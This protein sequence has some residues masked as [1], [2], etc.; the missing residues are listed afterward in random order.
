MYLPPGRRAA[1]LL[2]RRMRLVHDDRL[3]NDP[4]LPAL[5]RQTS[6]ELHVVEEDRVALVE[7]VVVRQERRVEAAGSSPT[8]AGRP[9]A[10]RN[11]RRASCSSRRRPLAPRAAA[12]GRAG[13]RSRVSS[14]RSGSGSG[15]AAVS[16]RDSRTAAPHPAAVGMRRAES[17]RGRSARRASARR[18]SSGAGR[19]RPS[20]VLYAWFTAAAKPTLRRCGSSTMSSAPRVRRPTVDRAVVDDDHLVASGRRR[21]RPAARRGT[22]ARALAC[23]S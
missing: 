7:E 19:T 5:V 16:R 11:P 6:G 22:R 10:S 17:G 12:D 18:R 15:T 21:C 20:R 13:C 1:Q 23:S 8:V 4:E 2:G 9:V 14:R 3:G